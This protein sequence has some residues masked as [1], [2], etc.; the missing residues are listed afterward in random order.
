MTR[1]NKRELKLDEMI[2]ILI[3]HDRRQNNLEKFN[4]SLSAKFNK[5]KKKNKNK[6]KN[7][8]NK[9]NKNK[10]NKKNF[11]T[12]EYCKLS[13]HIKSICFYLNV[14]GRPD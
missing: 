2:M 13:D 3:D 8:K 6:D 10:K 12:C 9:K 11:K 4:K 1:L 7:K 14:I 5:K